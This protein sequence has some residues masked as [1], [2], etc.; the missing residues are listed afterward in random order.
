MTND[1]GPSIDIQYSESVD[2]EAIR[3]MQCELEN[4]LSTGVEARLIHLRSLEIPMMI[5][6]VV[7]SA[8]WLL[9]LFGVPEYFKTRMQERARLD[10]RKAKERRMQSVRSSHWF[11]ASLSKHVSDGASITIGLHIPPEHFENRM[12]ADHFGGLLLKGTNKEMIAAELDLFLQYI[13]MLQHLIDTEITPKPILGGV[14]LKLFD[15]ALEVSWIP[16]ETLRKRVR[17]LRLDDG[18]A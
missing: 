2:K 11:V 6:I 9:R 17:V 3:A 16:Q 15:D 4:R 14:Y 7:A 12:K 13:S 1:T 10:A 5:S 8:A 18:T